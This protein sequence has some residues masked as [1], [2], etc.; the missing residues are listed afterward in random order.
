MLD[1]RHLLTCAHVVEQ[2]DA[3]LQVE[4]VA[5]PGAASGV[6]SVFDDFWIPPSGDERGDIAVLRLQEPETRCTGAPVHRMPLLR[7]RTV[8][9]YG[10]PGNGEMG[11]WF[12]GRQAHDGGPGGEWVQINK[13]AE[14]EPVSPGYSG[15][16]V[17]DDETGYVVGMM[18][19]RFATAA[20]L[21]SWMIPAE[22]MLGHL[23][24]LDRWF[25]GGSGV[26]QSIVE[27]PTSQVVDPVFSRDLAGYFAGHGP[28][29]PWVVV[30]GDSESALSTSLRLMIL[31][32]DR[33]RSASVGATMLPAD[34]VPPAGSLGLAVD[35]TAKTADDVRRRIEERLRPLT[36]SGVALPNRFSGLTLVIDA[37]DD[38]AEPARLIE[39]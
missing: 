21:V 1:S 12:T 18:V 28:S 13:A 34:A 11:V 4:F 8:S 7:G 16:A 32:A 38:A 3:L 5:L 24:G 17:V 2:V 33:E 23:P 37:I 31:L 10:F 14:S 15:A 27:R 9:A 20:N 36:E 22:T 30:T 29:A 6:A 35:A 25:Q 39:D 26:D 19:S